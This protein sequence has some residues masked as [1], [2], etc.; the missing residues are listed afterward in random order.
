VIEGFAL[1]LLLFPLQSD[2]APGPKCRSGKVVEG[3]PRRRVLPVEEHKVSYVMQLHACNCNWHAA[4]TCAPDYCAATSFMQEQVPFSGEIQDG[5]AAHRSVGVGR[6]DDWSL[7]SQKHDRENE[8]MPIRGVEAEQGKVCAVFKDRSHAS[9]RSVHRY[10]FY[11][12]KFPRARGSCSGE[13]ADD[14]SE[15]KREANR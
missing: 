14:S 11:I 10:G 13:L 4:R 12:G 2:C 5:A 7:R 9:D 15:E 1:R 6:P 8:R 3:L